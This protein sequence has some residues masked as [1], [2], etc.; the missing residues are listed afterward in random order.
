MEKEKRTDDIKAEFELREKRLKL[1]YKILYVAV[2]LWAALFVSYTTTEK[3][4]LPL[5]CGFLSAL[6]AAILNIIYYIFGELRC[7]KIYAPA[8]DE[9]KVEADSK[10]VEIW[11]SFGLGVSISALLT[12]IHTSFPAIVN[13]V[14]V[15][16]VV[17][18][19]A[20]L[21]AINSWFIK[22]KANPII[23]NM[24]TPVLC[25][26]YIMDTSSILS[27][28]PGETHTRLVYKSQWERI[29]EYMR[30]HSIVTC[31]EIF[32]E[33]KDKEIKEWIFS[34]QCTVLEIDDDIQNNV[35]KIVTENPKMIEFTGKS[36]T[37]SGDAFLIATA[38]KYGL[39]I[40]TEENKDKQ[41]KIPQISKKYG[42]TSVNIT[43]LCEMEQWKF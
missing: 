42:I 4:A 36:G 15:W 31:S 23:R 32:E 24:T 26:K 39:I 38:M 27:Q 41:M 17:G 9:S 33:I 16:I 3:S 43:S 35:R 10:F 30:S 37:S 2:A 34:Q 29:E 18:V 14:S 40:I 25:Y 5:Y 12:L 11:N 6:T 20:V 1:V 8:A 22:G 28:K 21:L 7:M 19:T 13:I